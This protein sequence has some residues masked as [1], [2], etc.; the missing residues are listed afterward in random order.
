[1][2]HLAT[3]TT[4]LLT[5]GLL[6]GGKTPTSKGPTPANPKASK[7]TQT[8]Y[9]WL[10]SLPDR[11]DNRIA[12]GQHLAHTTRGAVDGYEKYVKALAE[13]TG[14]WPV[15]IGM[16]YGVGSPKE[17]KQANAIAIG[18]AKRG[19]LVTIDIHPDNPWTGKNA[20]DVSQRDLADL[21][22][23]GTKAN[24]VWMKELDRMADGLEELRDA[25]VVV[26]WR[27]F[28]ENN[29]SKCWWWDQ[30]GWMKQPEKFK[31]A[32]R[33]MFEYFSKERKLDNLLWVYCVSNR[34]TKWNPALLGYPG[35][36]VVDI[37]GVDVYSDEYTIADNLYEKF[38]RSGKPFA[39]AEN[40][41]ASHDGKVAATKL[42]ESIRKRY[43]RTCYFQFWHSW[44]DAPVALVDQP[45]A[46]A[47]LDDPWVIT[48]DEMQ[49]KLR[50]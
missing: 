43:P 47:L 13:K 27:P 41:P 23:P 36:D 18:H 48:C 7:A 25:G 19:G 35:D 14:K 9:A 50:R 24:A 12:S 42:I 46:K 16:D 37:L 29:F 21:I 45:K 6:V 34:D 5:A 40:G 1:M 2:K 17:I 30:G 33:H 49:A 32:W 11:K 26:L 31:N 38:L 22:T 15:I 3:L 4:I 28:H 8:V 44:K 20:R 10:A 39:I